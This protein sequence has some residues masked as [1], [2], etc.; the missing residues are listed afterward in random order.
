MNETL[1]K[2][3]HILIVDDKPQ[4]IQI[5]GKTLREHQYEITVANSGKQALKV[6]EKLLPD[7]ILLDIM[8]P[9]MDGFEVCAQLKASANTRDIPVI[10]LTAYADSDNLVKGFE[11]GAIDYITK[12]FH[13]AEVIARVKTQLELKLSKEILQEKNIQQ[14]ELLHILC[15]DLANPISVIKTYLN[16][17]EIE[18]ELLRE[19][20]DTMVLAVDNALEIIEFVRKMRTL[21]EKK[22]GFSLEAIPL[23]TT[24]QQSIAVLQEKFSEKNIT[25]IINVDDH[26]SILGEK[27]SFTNSVLNNVLTNA[28]KFSFPNGQI[29]IDAQ[30]LDNFITIT[31]KDFGIGMSEQLVHDVFDISKETNRK[32]TQGETG[33]GFGIPLIT[34]FIT[35]YGGKIDLVSKEKS[36]DS[37]THGTEVKLTL[38]AA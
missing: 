1:Y 11:C 18:P 22:I 7:L 26:L 28:I 24:I 38:K 37:D 34:K 15:H 6:V 17:A 14:K 16:F 30:K 27:I 2:N 35:A 32:G 36:D 23:K 31:V 5:L 19:K 3:P 20:K 8:M 21:E 12:P 25:L 9:E 4:N 10:F 13:I 33:T 29:I